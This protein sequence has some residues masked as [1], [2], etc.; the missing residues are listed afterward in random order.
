[1]A[2][3]QGSTAPTAD[4][5][6]VRG[7]SGAD[8]AILGAAPGPTTHSRRSRRAQERIRRTHRRRRATGAAVVVAALI[9][10][11]TIVTLS[12]PP[13]GEVD[14]ETVRSAADTESAMPTKP[15]A[16]PPPGT[17]RPPEPSPSKSRPPKGSPKPTTPEPAPST[18]KT[19][20][21]E[22][23]PKPTPT[24]DPADSPA[25]QVLALVNARRAEAGCRPVKLDD[26]LSRAAQLHSE[27]MSANDYFDHTSKDGRTFSDRAKAQGYQT[28]GAENIAQGQ[29]S[30]DAVMDAWMNSQGHRE[31]ILNCDLSTMGLGLVENDWTWTQVFGF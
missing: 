2:D 23:R 8:T 24:A 15:V 29:S 28:P 13:D 21:P 3:H 19:A 11:G 1:M 27:D 14:G 31:N 26:R 9:A 18:T 4:S 10:G 17:S 16:S 25:E 22:P 6:S 12:T 20:T 7:E 5:I 30:A